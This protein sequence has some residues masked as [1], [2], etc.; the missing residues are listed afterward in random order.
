[1]KFGRF[2]RILIVPV[3][4]TFFLAPAESRAVISLCNPGWPDPVFHDCGTETGIDVVL[5]EYFDVIVT[6]C[7]GEAATVLLE[8]AYA[9]PGQV[10]DDDAYHGSDEVR[11]VFTDTDQQASCPISGVASDSDVVVGLLAT[12][13][14][15]TGMTPQARLIG[16]PIQL[17]RFEDPVNTPT[18]Q[19]TDEMRGRLREEL[20]QRNLVAPVDAGGCTPLFADTSR[21]HLENR[22][23]DHWRGIFKGKI[24]CAETGGPSPSNCVNVHDG[25]GVAT[26]SSMIGIDLDGETCSY[27]V[28]NGSTSPGFPDCCDPQGEVDSTWTMQCTRAILTELVLPTGGMA[29][30]PFYWTHS[31]AQDEIVKDIEPSLTNTTLPPTPENV[32]FDCFDFAA[33]ETSFDTVD[34]CSDLGGAFADIDSDGIFD[35]CDYFVSS[36]SDEEGGLDARLKRY[37][38]NQAFNQSGPD[39]DTFANVDDVVIDSQ[40]ATILSRQADLLE[41]TLPTNL[42]LGRRDVEVFDTGEPV[43]GIARDKLVV[44]RVG[45]M[46]I[47]GADYVRPFDE[48][49]GGFVDLS[50]DFEDSVPD[51]PVAGPDGVAFSVEPGNENKELYISAGSE[52]FVYDDPNNQLRDLDDGAAGIQGALVGAEIGQLAVEPHGEFAFVVHGGERV[53]IVQVQK[54]GIAPADRFAAYSSVVHVAPAVASDLVVKRTGPANE[55]FAVYI[56]TSCRGCTYG[57]QAECPPLGG[58]GMDGMMDTMSGDNPIVPCNPETGDCGGGG[59][60]GGG[61]PVTYTRTVA[62]AVHILQPNYL[63]GGVLLDPSDPWTTVC[64]RYVQLSEVT[65]TLSETEPWPQ[66]GMDFSSDGS[67]LFVVDPESDSLFIINTATNELVVEPLVPIAVG[68]YPFD[69]EVVD[70]LASGSMQAR[71]YVVNHGSESIPDDDSMTIVNTTT[72]LPV[73][74]D[75]DLDDEF[76]LT[77]LEV[78]TVTG[79]SAFLYLVSPN[80]DRLLIYDVRLDGDNPQVVGD[81]IVGPLPRRVAGRVQTE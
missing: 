2:L 31:R 28:P 37:F 49:S 34:T 17:Q 46:S 81:F 42:T 71:A 32:G 41:F 24:I 19:L 35:A 66:I 54:S 58:D 22:G 40:S 5:D 70:V 6:N 48:A 63:A 68:V 67:E 13:Y 14:R 7:S 56:G 74:P 15:P 65:G 20:Q 53:G 3:A 73:P 16:E 26:R 44:Q 1:M 8:M 50:P 18:I 78:E 33:L 10:I 47:G 38:R 21:A 36:I 77:D 45:F 25:V 12:A 55:Q 76:S 57:T 64:E 43:P 62:V 39:F 79:S 61:D 23:R 30:N 4:L 59:G 27:L 60:G 11:I 75:R 29:L 80:R 52:V 9:T 69:V 72:R 51:L